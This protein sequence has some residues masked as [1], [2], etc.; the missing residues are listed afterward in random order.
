MEN[1]SV[2]IADSGSTKTDWA[3]MGMRMQTQ[4]INP[5]HQDEDTIRG[6]LKD[7]LLPQLTSDIRHLTSILFYGSGVRPELEEKM[8]RLLGEAFPQAE[9]IEAHG[10][11]LGAAR[12]LCNNEEGIA[13]ILGTGANSCLYDG[14]RIVKNTPPMGYILGDEG[15]GA[16][17]GA[18]F[19][20]A[21]YKNRLSNEVKVAFEAYSGMSMAQVIERVYRQPMANRWLASLSAFIHEQIGNPQIEQL[22]IDNFRDFIQRDIAPYQRKDLPINA[23]G[24]IAFYYQ[25]Q[26][27]KAVKEEG[28]TLGKIVR[29][30]L[31]ALVEME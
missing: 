24:S 30:P 16:V 9:H 20:N 15:S 17:L 11:L 22:V 4:G 26:L 1:H 8:R 12:A 14:E 6:I 7:E 5:F 18:R 27:E 10:D 21:L 29:S 28:Y 25:Q 13:C 23:V 2:L 3:F 31:D 19:L